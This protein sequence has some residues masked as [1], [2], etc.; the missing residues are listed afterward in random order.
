[1]RSG[2]YRQSAKIQI[3]SLF[4]HISTLGI[5][6]QSC[7]QKIESL[8]FIPVSFSSDREQSVM[9]A[10]LAYSPVQW[11]CLMW[12]KRKETKSLFPA[13]FL[14]Q[15]A[16]LTGQQHPP[17]F[18]SRS[19]FSCYQFWYW[20]GKKKKKSIL[21]FSLCDHK[22]QSWNNF[23]MLPRVYLTTANSNCMLNWSLKSLW[24]LV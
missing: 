19:Y 2:G 10:S 24:W 13:L 18:F 5:V 3:R 7:Y 1:M 12:G 11:Y 23:R 8:L 6:S 16:M 20:E 22:I 15:N 4:F 9:T 17:P 14:S 21:I